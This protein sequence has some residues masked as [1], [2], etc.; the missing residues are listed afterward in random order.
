MLCELTVFFWIFAKRP[1]SPCVITCNIRGQPIPSWMSPELYGAEIYLPF[2]E[3]LLYPLKSCRRNLI[4]LLHKQSLKNA[5]IFFISFDP[6]NHVIVFICILQVRKQTEVILKLGFEFRS[7]DSKFH[8][9][10]IVLSY[11]TYLH[12]K[13]NLSL[14]LPRVGG[15]SGGCPHCNVKCMRT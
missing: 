11:P 5:F 6:Y 4:L 14:T 10:S 15:W 3:T 7:S 9:T 1:V 13:K 12:I 8:V 2:G